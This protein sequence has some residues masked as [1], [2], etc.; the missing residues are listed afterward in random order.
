MPIPVGEV[1][2]LSAPRRRAERF[3]WTGRSH[4][5]T[6]LYRDKM[7]VT[8][9]GSVQS[10]AGR[11]RPRRDARTTRPSG[12]PRS[13]TMLRPGHRPEAPALPGAAALRVTYQGCA[14]KWHLLS[15]RD[16]VR[17]PGHACGPDRWRSTPA[18]AQRPV[19]GRRRQKRRR[20]R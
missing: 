11:D 15:A 5:D 18:A 16:E 17:R 13:I 4:P 14:E 19:F 1:F 6:Y 20:R 9:P 2:R 12:R 8:P 7:V 10:D 3:A